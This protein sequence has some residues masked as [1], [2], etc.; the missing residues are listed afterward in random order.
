LIAKDRNGLLRAGGGGNAKEERED[1][2]GGPHE[3]EIYISFRD[4][5]T[6]RRFDPLPSPV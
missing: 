1:G 6:C 2:G 5:A 4:H 3:T